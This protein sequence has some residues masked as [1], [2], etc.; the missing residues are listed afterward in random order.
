[1]LRVKKQRVLIPQNTLLHL[2]TYV[3]N[4]HKETVLS[5]LHNAGAGN[6]GDY[7]NCSLVTGEGRFT[8]GENSKPALGNKKEAAKVDEEALV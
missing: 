6:I 1:M 7:G 8:P 3:P 5:A 2:K 4:A